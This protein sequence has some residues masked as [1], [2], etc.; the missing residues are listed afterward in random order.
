MMNLAFNENAVGEFDENYKV[1][2]PLRTES[3]RL[4][5]VQGVLDGT[6]DAIMSNHCPDDIESKNVEFEYAT[7]GAA[8]LPSFFNMILYT[9]GSDFNKIVETLV[10]GANKIYNMPERNFE[11]GSMADFTIF[12][13]EISHIITKQNQG[14]KAYN[15]LG[16]NKTSKGKV[17]AVVSKGLLHN[18]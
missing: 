1:Y 17:I 14:T 8:T 11:V 15:V 16:L 2:P 7:F 18:N 3:D 4:A 10:N 5:L 6:I 12:S 13:T 9:F